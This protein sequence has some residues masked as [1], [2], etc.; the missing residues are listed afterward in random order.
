[1]IEAQDQVARVD[2]WID[3]RGLIRRTVMNTA[4]QLTGEAGASMSM[5]MD[6]Y[7]FGVAPGVD[8]PDDALTFDAT[9]LALQGLESAASN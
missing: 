6:F 1:M 9:A 8:A 4:L 7:D 5:T 2:V 3:R